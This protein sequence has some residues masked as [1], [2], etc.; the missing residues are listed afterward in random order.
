L[1]RFTRETISDWLD[2]N[3]FR[4]SAALA[5]YILFSLGPLLLLAVALTGIFFG[6][7][8]ASG[9]LSAQLRGWLGPQGA[10]AVQSL[11]AGMDQPRHNLIASL[12]SI[13]VLLFGATGV[14][15]ELKSSLNEI[16]EFK[17]AEPSGWK[18]LLRDRLASFAM[19][20]V[21]GFLLLVSLILSSIL[22]AANTQLS[23]WIAMPPIFFHVISFLSSLVVVTLLF[24]LIFKILPDAPVRWRD[25]WVGA[26]TTSVL[27]S[28]GRTLIALYLGRATATSVYGASGSVM[29][30]LL[31][32]YYSSLI[33]FLGAE[34]THVFSKWSGSPSLA[35]AGD[36]GRLANL[37]QAATNARQIPGSKAECPASG[38]KK[39]SASGQARCNAHAESIGQHMS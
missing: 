23:Q 9:Q 7:S 3:A 12:I 10:S 34:F 30:V 16:W 33:L 19:V 35:G 8:A 24:A 15:T 20:L 11:I 2:H 29:V 37:S 18:T 13:G 25:V 27:F 5:Y 32:A 36:Q 21:I 26:L 17:A 39:N 22:A 38:I 4:L 1:V 28:I 14:F 31:W 6:H